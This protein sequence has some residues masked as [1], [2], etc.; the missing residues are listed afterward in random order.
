MTAKLP[1]DHLLDSCEPV[2]AH[3]LVRAMERSWWTVPRFFQSPSYLTTGGYLQAV[4]D[5][6]YVVLKWR[7]FYAQLQAYA[8]LPPVGLANDPATAM[9]YARRAADQLVAMGLGLRLTADDARTLG[10]QLPPDPPVADEYLYR[11]GDVANLQGPAWRRLRN[12]RS[13]ARRLIVTHQATHAVPQDVLQLAADWA[14]DRGK[15]STTRAHLAHLIPSPT[16]WVLAMRWQGECLGY[17]VDDVVPQGVVTAWRARSY[18][19]SAPLPDAVALVWHLAARHL[20]DQGMSPDAFLN[21][22]FA[23]DPGQLEYRLR[24]HPVGTLPVYHV[25]GRVQLVGTDYR[26]P[27][28]KAA[29]LEAWA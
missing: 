19:H 15:G 29:Q 22:G 6:A 2:D 13:Q 26:P 3:D 24:M 16:T 14:V 1:L 11:L 4:V 8:V 20:L 25:P 9:H 27:G 21:L 7:R 10:V 23:R 5:D 18:R 17:S 28:R 12:L